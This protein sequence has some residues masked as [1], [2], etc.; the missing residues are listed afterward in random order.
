MRELIRIFPFE[1]K[2]SNK[3]VSIDLSRKPFK[4]YFEQ[5]LLYVAVR[6]AFAFEFRNEVRGITFL[7]TRFVSIFFILFS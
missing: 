1:L 2:T 3:I 5:D 7:N 4:I 6:G